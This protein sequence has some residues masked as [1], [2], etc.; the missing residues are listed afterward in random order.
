VLTPDSSRFWP[1]ESYR[2]GTSPPS[3]DKQFLRD[4][5]EAVRT[6][7]EA[8]DKKAPPPKVPSKVVDETAD[9]YAT[10][11]STLVPLT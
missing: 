8:W 10:A 3:Y 1:V 2:E 11:F 4:W 7:G 6:D 5:L 9:R